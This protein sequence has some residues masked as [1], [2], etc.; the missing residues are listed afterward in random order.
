MAGSEHAEPAPLCLTATQSNGDT[1]EKHGHVQGRM[2]RTASYAEK[3]LQCL[4]LQTGHHR[5]LVTGRL[6]MA[7]I[8]QCA[9][10]TDL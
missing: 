5:V 1:A 8:S 9:H 10:F 7:W 6:N 4:G 2:A 3:L